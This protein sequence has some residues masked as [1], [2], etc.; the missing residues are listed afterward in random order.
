[1]KKRNRLLIFFILLMILFLAEKS[2][3][4]QENITVK[5]G[6]LIIRHEGKT[7]GPI[8]GIP[9]IG[10]YTGN[11]TKD[12]NP[13]DVID[14]GIRDG[15]GVIRPSQSTDATRFQD[16]GFYSVLESQIP[17]KHNGQVS[18][19][20]ALPEDTK[21]RI[22]SEVCKM[23]EN[24]LGSTYGKYKS[25]Q[26]PKGHSVNCGDWVLSLYDKALKSEGLR[27]MS[28]KYPRRHKR[29]EGLKLGE[30]RDYSELLWGTTDPSRLHRW[31]PEVGAPQN[32]GGVYLAPSPIKEGKGGKEMMERVLE[33]RPSGDSLSWPVEIPEMGK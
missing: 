20:S 5:P 28:H 24:D 9:H 6:D 1:M 2:G 22:R 27:V 30:L 7:L 13:Y 10:L 17:I 21:N 12:G 11:R 32:R 4:T 15:N 16:P 31:L 3:R 26:F 23:A 19:L 33:S 18:T 14:L 8:G 25:S 29:P